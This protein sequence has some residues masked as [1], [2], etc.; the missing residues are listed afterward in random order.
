MEEQERDIVTFIDDEGNELEL[1]V[2]D[3]FDFEGDEYAILSDLNAAEEAADD[4]DYEQELFVFKVVV[5]GEDESFLPAD[6][7]KMDALSAIVDELM[8]QEEDAE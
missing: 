7:D 2:L 1:D 3:Y 5:D 6:E 8:M 4:P